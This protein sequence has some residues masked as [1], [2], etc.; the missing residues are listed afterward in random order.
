MPAHELQFPAELLSALRTAQQIAVFTGAGISAESGVPTFREAQTGLSSKYD[1]Q[2][3][4]TPEAF[5]RNPQLVWQ[6]Y[7]WRR[8]LVA[9]AK[10]NPGHKALAN[11]ERIVPHLTLI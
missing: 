9:Q 8:E 1:P 11:M 3:L 2:E 5:H 7:A 6:W 4:A 10:P